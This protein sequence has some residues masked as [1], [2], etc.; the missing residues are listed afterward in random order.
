MLLTADHGW[1][2]GEHNEWCKQTLFDVTLHIPFIIRAPNRRFG[3]SGRHT[4]GMAELVDLYRTLADLA[5]LPPPA[6]G[7]DG[8]SLAPLLDNPTPAAG[9]A[10]KTAAYSQ[11]ARCLLC[12]ASDS[13]KGRCPP[14]VK[15][16][17]VYSPYVGKDDCANVPREEIG[18]MGFTMRTPSWRFT[19]WVAWNGEA[20]RPDWTKVNATELYA[21]DCDTPLCDNDFDRWDNENVAEDHA[22]TVAAL[23]TRLQ[24]HFYPTTILKSEDE[25]GTAP[26]APPA[27]GSTFNLHLLS[28]P[29]ALC[30]DGSPAAFY[31]GRASKPTTKWMI[32][33]EGKAW[34][35]SEAECDA[36]A[37]ATDGRGGWKASG[38]PAKPGCLPPTLPWGAAPCSGHAGQAWGCQLSNDCALNPAFCD[39]NMVHVKTC[40]GGSWSGNRSSLSPSGLHYRGKAIVDATVRALRGLGIGTATEIVIGGGSAGALGVY[41]QADYWLAQLDPKH[42]KKVAAVP[43]C[44]FFQDWKNNSFHQGFAWMHSEAGMQSAVDPRCAAAHPT[45]PNLCLMAEHA[46]PFISTPLFALQAKFD[47]WQKGNVCGAD[48]ATTAG[49]QAFGDALVAK[50][51]ATV[52][53]KKGN[54]AFVDSCLHHCGGSDTYRNDNLTQARALQTWFEHGASA[55]PQAGRLISESAYPCAA[56]C[57]GKQPQSLKSEDEQLISSVPPVCSAAPPGSDPLRPCQPHPASDEAAEHRS[58]GAQFKLM[59]NGRCARG[60]EPVPNTSCATAALAVGI[61]VTGQKIGEGTYNSN[62]VGCYWNVANGPTA[63]YYND[64]GNPLLEDIR[65]RVICQQVPQGQKAQCCT[66]V[67]NLTVSNAFS[68]D[69]ILQRDGRGSSVFGTAP[70]NAT[71]AVTLDGGAPIRAAAGLDPWQAAQGEIPNGWIVHLPPHA[72]SKNE[73]HMIKIE[74]TDGCESGATS[75]TLER[76][77]FGDV[78][79]C[80]GQSNMELILG[81]S[82]SWYGEY[83]A[84]D[85]WSKGKN[86]SNDT[87]YPIHFAHLNHNLVIPG[88]SDTATLPWTPA[89]AAESTPSGAAK[90]WSVPAEVGWWGLRGFSAAW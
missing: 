48:C 1:Q 10:F 49:E 14:G 90:A 2:L 75:V 59:P 5:G 79:I 17:E 23:R 32:W 45:A 61:N 66:P 18:W 38:W 27:A 42:D 82:F 22:S 71:I 3:R 6:A 34:C 80:A 39:F 63:V 46:A 69:M 51:R 74:C 33:G 78:L 68:S 20:L 58:R 30:L 40:D 65:R 83:E 64:G 13:K 50:L 36:R 26:P 41:L 52:L 19:T 7:V 85:V 76:V 12:Q 60:Y 84:T 24:Q 16:G 4:S 8:T 25:Q 43:D 57:T 72:A 9:P 89:N 86:I 11:M 31:F 29:G 47:S 15:A 55:L 53:A 44:G 37:K 21:H 77:M 87:A 28:D 56:C 62:P 70:A 54:G 81:V 88:P 35:L 73:T 67:S